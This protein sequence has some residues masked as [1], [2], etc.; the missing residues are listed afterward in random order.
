M[1]YITAAESEEELKRR[2]DA[3]WA[4]R[5]PNRQAAANLLARYYE[6][7]EEANVLFTSH[8]EGWKTDR[9]MIY[10]VFGPPAYV[11]N[12]FN[13]R[14]WYYYERGGIV[15]RALPP[16]IFQR[17]SAYGLSGMFDHYI[18]QRSERYEEEWRRRR[19]QWRDGRV[20]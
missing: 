20:L 15:S 2:F 10:I 7:V 14:D 18:L 19:D 3:F 11:E 12:R 8:K 13:R 5:V 17:S 4:E 6:R 16:F 1:D 9:G